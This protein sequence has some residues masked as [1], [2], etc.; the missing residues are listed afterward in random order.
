MASSSITIKS[1][2]ND[3]SPY[4]I[5]V[6]LLLWV[7][8]GHEFIVTSLIMYW[9]PES[10]EILRLAFI[11]ICIGLLVTCKYPHWMTSSSPS[12]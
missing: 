2:L 8:V 12:M 10:E 3:W 11:I 5:N 1:T 7:I 4:L 9:F 6:A